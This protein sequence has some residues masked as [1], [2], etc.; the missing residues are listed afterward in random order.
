MSR[1]QK[2]SLQ[3]IYSFALK[4]G[5]S[6]L[7]VLSLAN[8]ETDCMKQNIRMNLWQ[9]T[10]RL[11]AYR[12]ESYQKT[13]KTTLWRADRLKV[14]TMENVRGSVS[15]FL[16]ICSLSWQINRLSNSAYMHTDAWKQLATV[17]SLSHPALKND[18]VILLGASN[19][20]LVI[21]F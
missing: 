3:D 21:Y 11:R 13:R 20:H 18:L 7:R 10:L 19:V 17:R 8:K 16:L 14:A 1:K 6:Y 4:T 9:H 2:C 15:W 5:W 12:S